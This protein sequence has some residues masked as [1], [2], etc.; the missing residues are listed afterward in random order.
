[1]VWGKC[2]RED[3]RHDLMSLFVEEAFRR[4][5]NHATVVREDAHRDMSPVFEHTDVVEV[6]SPSRVDTSTEEYDLAAGWIWIL[7]PFDGDGRRWHISRQGTQK[8]AIHRLTEICRCW[9]SVR[10]CGPIFHV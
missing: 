7:P 2:Q 10:L 9:R 8:R 4:A 6:H 1:M 5:I 3:R